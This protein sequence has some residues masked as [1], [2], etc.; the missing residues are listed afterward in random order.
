MK[1]ITITEL[2]AHAPKIVS[3]IQSSGE[4]VAITKNGKPVA[5]MRPV[6]ANEFMLK[7]SMKG[8]KEHG[9]GKAKGKT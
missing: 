8:V 7:T 2:R 6:E 3:D 4:E 1:F 9:K 5:L